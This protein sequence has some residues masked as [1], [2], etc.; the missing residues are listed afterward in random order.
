MID[1][2]FLLQDRLQKIRQ[3]VN[4]YGEENFYIS[5]SGGKDSTV[6]SALVD[7]ALPDNKIPRVYANTGIEYRL[8]LEFV[9]KVRQEDHPWDLVILKPSVP[10]KPMLEE[11][12]YPFKSKK[13]AKNVSIYQRY[14]KTQSIKVY[15]GECSTSNKPDIE[16]LA[17]QCPKK[18]RYQFET[19]NR[20]KISDKCCYMLKEKPM[21]NYSKNAKR[22]Y[23]IIGIMASEGGRRMKAKC[24][25]FSGDKLK[26]FQPLVPVTKEWEDWFIDAYNVE[27]CDIYKP[28]YNFERTGCKGCPFALHLQEELDTLEK[29]FPAERK[30]CEIIWK[31][32]YDEYR[33]I[34]YRLRKDRTNEKYHQYTL[35]ELYE[36]KRT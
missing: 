15:L 20:I 4:K 11:Y 26:A 25:A 33:R 35:L 16:P 9:E 30:Q 23:A 22:P 10:I 34:G 1:N 8:I 32:V 13:H 28:P 3:I 12:G 14:G 31:P 36:N 5:F 27:I 18:L 6:L 2:E 24:L 19:K 7:M 29:F 21:V 17:F